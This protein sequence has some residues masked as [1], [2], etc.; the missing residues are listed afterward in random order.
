VFLTRQKLELVSQQ[1]HNLVGML[2]PN[3]LIADASIFPPYN[4]APGSVTNATLQHVRTILNVNESEQKHLAIVPN[5]IQ[6]T[7]YGTVSDAQRGQ[8]FANF[9]NAIEKF[10]K[11][12]NFIILDCNP[13]TTLLSNCALNAAT[14]IVVPLRADKYTTEGLENI[15]EVLTNFLKIEFAH[16]P[17]RDRKQLWTLINF[18][19]KGAITEANEERAKGKGPEAELLRDI[20]NPLKAGTRLGQFKVSLLDT[21][22]PESGFLRSKAIDTEQLNP[23]SPP[24]RN[25]LRIFSHMRARPVGDAFGRLASELSTRTRSATQVISV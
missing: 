2:E 6:A 16:G 23:N 8:I 4:I 12:Y 19:D 24:S 14:D 7:K 3:R 22:I 17:G 13:S 25:L 21:R 18:A 9:Q 15:D 20:F 5:A 10:S 1:S 11:Q